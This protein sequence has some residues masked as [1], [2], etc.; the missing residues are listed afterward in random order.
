MRGVVL[1]SD[2]RTELSVIGLVN[3]I[4]ISSDVSVVLTLSFEADLFH[5]EC[6]H[7]KNDKTSDPS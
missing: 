4:Y 5:S 2:W 3:I 6:A 7:L 1:M